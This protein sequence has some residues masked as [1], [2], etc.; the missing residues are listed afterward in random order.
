MPRVLYI[1]SA[2]TSSEAPK[3][4]RKNIYHAPGAWS[5]TL[6][7]PAREDEGIVFLVPQRVIPVGLILEFAVIVLLRQLEE[8]F[9]LRRLQMLA[10]IANPLPDVI[11]LVFN[12]VIVYIRCFRHIPYYTGFIGG[13]EEGSP[14]FMSFAMAKYT[15]QAISAPATISDGQWTPEA[16]RARAFRAAAA[17]NQPAHSL[18]TLH[19]ANASAKRK[20]AWP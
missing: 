20:S 18:R 16:I 13:T 6:V 2:D 12:L 10:E 1:P 7:L 9:R 4:L 19:T 17:K 14:G 15:P 8:H 5:K 11:G 3:W